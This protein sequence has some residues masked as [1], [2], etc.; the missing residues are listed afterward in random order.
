MPLIPNSQICPWE[1]N[2]PIYKLLNSDWHKASSSKYLVSCY[3][4][5]LDK[6]FFW[7]ISRGSSEHGHTPENFKILGIFFFPPDSQYCWLVWNLLV[8]F[9]FLKSWSIFGLYRSVSSQNGSA[10]PTPSLSPTLRLC[11]L[12]TCDSFLF[13]LHVPIQS[14]IHSTSIYH[15]PILYWDTR[16]LRQAWFHLQGNHVLAEDTDEK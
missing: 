10:W 16:W 7:W 8:N 6:C 14:P 13:Q 2:D 4:P 9:L 1:W 11:F 5:L 12:E 3:F 15:M